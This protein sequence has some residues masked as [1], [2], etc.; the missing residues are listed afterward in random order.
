MRQTKSTTDNIVLLLATGTYLGNSRFAP[1]TLG[2][3]WGVPLA[4]AINKAGLATGGGILVVAIILSIILSSHASILIGKKDPGSVVADEIVGYCVAIFALPFTPVT[5]ILAFILFRIFDILKP[6]PVSYLD[7]HIGGGL[8]I[9]LDDLAAGVM[10]AIVLN[11][12]MR[13]IL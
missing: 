12:I 10:A 13:I 3:L 5:V 1:G 7:K 4:Y 8:G 2:T 9:V 6:F 11:I